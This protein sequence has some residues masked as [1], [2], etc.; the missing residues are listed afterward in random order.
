M[1]YVKKCDACGLEMERPGESI[2]QIHGS[3][4]EQMTD[5]NRRIEYRYLTPHPNTKLAFH[6]VG[7][8]QD[9]IVEQQE[10]NPF[11]PRWRRYPQE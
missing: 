6:D 10:R 7:C 4:S 5:A 8:L 11:I 9:W 1:A 3:I 2:I